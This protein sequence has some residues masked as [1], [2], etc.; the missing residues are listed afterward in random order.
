MAPSRAQAPLLPL[1]VLL[2][3]VGLAT[4][5]CE[6]ASDPVAGDLTYSVRYRATAEFIATGSAQ[7]DRIVYDDEDGNEI[8]VTVFADPN[9]WSE[10]IMLASGDTYF[11]RAEG[12]VDS[13]RLIVQVELFGSDGSFEVFSGS[14]PNFDTGSFWVQVS[15]DTLP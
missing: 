15:R 3:A 2:L 6:S 14:M 11:V 10:T 8:E 7:L 12:T 13:G 4:T 1:L 9:Q 5:G